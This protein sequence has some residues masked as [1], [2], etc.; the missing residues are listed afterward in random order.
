MLMAH[1]KMR[2]QLQLDGQQL[3]VLSA[4]SAIYQNKAEHDKL[5]S[6]LNREG[7]TRIVDELYS[8]QLLGQ[9][10]ILVADLDYFKQ[11]NDTHGHVIGDKVLQEA[12][13]V[14]TK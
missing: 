1:I 3:Q 9:Y 12:A 7:L 11:V 5:T 10:A 14:L 6:V 13:N 4:K 8:T 2:A